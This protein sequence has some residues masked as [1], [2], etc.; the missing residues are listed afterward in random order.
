MKAR[1]DCAS[2]QQINLS[3]IACAELTFISIYDAEEHHR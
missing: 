2:Q 3:A 1:S